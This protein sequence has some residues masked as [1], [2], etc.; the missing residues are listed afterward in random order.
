MLNA[1]FRG[2]S[3]EHGHVVSLSYRR[4]RK[5]YVLVV[6]LG[7]LAPDDLIRVGINAA[8]GVYAHRQPVFSRKGGVMG[9]GHRA[10]PHHHPYG[11]LHLAALR[12]AHALIEARRVSGEQSEHL[13][14][15]A[16]RSD[17]LRISED[18][19]ILRLVFGPKVVTAE[20]LPAL[21]T[22]IIP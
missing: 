16:A 7:P 19:S 20:A 2:G 15:V 8:V 11:E 18:V 10:G 22:V 6:V 4:H 21:I 13:L 17:A 3:G 14:S 5:L 12:H 9:V 1:P